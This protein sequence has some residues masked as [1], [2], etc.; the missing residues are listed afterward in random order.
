[1][2]AG[3]TNSN[4]SR[5]SGKQDEIER[6]AAQSMPLNYRMTRGEERNLNGIRLRHAPS[7]RDSPR[8]EGPRIDSSPVAH[9]GG[10]LS[11]AS[12]ICPLSLSSLSFCNSLPCSPCVSSPSTISFNGGVTNYRETFISSGEAETR[13]TKIL[14][15]E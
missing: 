10:K 8:F 1:M 11:F 5:D 15:P 14:Q 9:F 12:E 7:L 6:A 13:R 2:V 3:G 4:C